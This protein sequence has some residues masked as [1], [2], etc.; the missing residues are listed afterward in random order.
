MHS[1]AALLL[2]GQEQNVLLRERLTAR[3]ILGLSD[4]IF[5]V[6]KSRLRLKPFFNN[7]SVLSCCNEEHSK[8]GH[9]VRMSVSLGELEHRGQAPL[10]SERALLKEDKW[11]YVDDLNV[12]SKGVGLNQSCFRLSFTG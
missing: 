5:S 4:G 9:N 10:A 3:S 7:Y 11:H 12:I 8:A 6:I 2:S 1:D